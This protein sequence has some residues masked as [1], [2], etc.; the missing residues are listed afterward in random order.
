LTS[1]RVA[2]HLGCTHTPHRLHIHT[3]PL[4]H[5]PHTY[6]AAKLDKKAAILVAGLQQRDT[7]LRAQLDEVAQQVRVWCGVSF[8]CKPVPCVCVCVSALHIG[9]I[10]IS[11][12]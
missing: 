2:C 1:G 12:S 6:R 10:R 5:A 9:G 8:G 11:L 3:H 7:K 4:A